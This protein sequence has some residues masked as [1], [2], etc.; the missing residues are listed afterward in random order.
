VRRG[1]AF[2]PP[3]DTRALGGVT[4]FEFPGPGRLR[5]RVALRPERP[6]GRR[7]VDRLVAG[8]FVP[9]AAHDDTLRL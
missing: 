4:K 9:R 8:F 5:G 1:V 6:F 3:A 7:D 2:A